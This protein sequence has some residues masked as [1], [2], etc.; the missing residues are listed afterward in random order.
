VNSRASHESA[1]SESEPASTPRRAGPRLLRWAVNLWLVF[2]LSA[3]II[4]PAAVSPS[5]DLIRS[6]WAVVRPYIQAL[7]LNHGYHYFAPEPGESTLLAFE[8]ELGDG[9]VIRGRIP[10][11][12]I[13]P[14]LLYHRHFMLTEH[15][16][17]AAPEIQDQWYASYAEHIAHAYGAKRVRLTRLIHYLPTMEE[18]RSGVALD[19]PGSYEEEPLGDFR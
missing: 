18:V 6:A 5:S 15:M 12:R 10:D 19:D 3:I 9:T 14:R 7:Y 2:H 1:T 16:D 17:L 8:A 4:A 13:V 11:R